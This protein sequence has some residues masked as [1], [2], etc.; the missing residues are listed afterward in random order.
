MQN[1]PCFLI[2]WR[3]D[4]SNAEYGAARFGVLPTG[5]RCSGVEATPDKVKA[6]EWPVCLVRVSSQW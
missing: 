5:A 2:L 6:P 1:A 3:I 4:G